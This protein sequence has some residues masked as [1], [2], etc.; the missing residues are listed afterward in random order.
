MRH[1]LVILGGGM[2]KHIEGAFEVTGWSEEQAP[3][4]EGA[5]KV[6]IARIEQRFTGG[7]QAETIS[8]TVMTYRE[9][10]TAEFLGYQRVQGGIG[11]KVGAFVFRATGNFDGKEARTSIEVVPNSATGDLTGLRGTGVATAPLGTTGTFTLDYE[12]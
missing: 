1:A 12:L 4:L 11:D 10:G 3:G 2:Q 5:A 9:D 6:T 7:I 8:D